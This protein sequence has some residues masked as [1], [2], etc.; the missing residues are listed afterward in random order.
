MN[1][2]DK[3]LQELQTLLEFVSEAI[4]M[5]QDDNED[6]SDNNSVSLAK[7]AHAIKQMHAKYKTISTSLHEAYS[8][9]VYRDIPNA[10][11]NEGITTQNIIGVGKV[12]IKENISV[13]VK[14]INALHLFISKN[15]YDSIIKT[16]TKIHPQTLKACINHN[17][18]DVVV[19]GVEVNKSQEAV[20][21][22]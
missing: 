6:N 15:G 17:F 12:R 22:K 21:T 11:T 19:D 20:F 9:L 2:T 16:E 4:N 7:K 14:D 13:K 10:M 18:S 1:N 5:L 3:A 8:S